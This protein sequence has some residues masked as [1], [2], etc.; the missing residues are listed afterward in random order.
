[1]LFLGSQGKN[2][3]EVCHIPLQWTQLVRPLHH[4]LS[5]LGGS[6][7]HGLVIALDKAVVHVVRLADFAVTVVSVCLCS[8]ALSELLPS[9]LG[10]CY[11]GHG[12]SLHGSSSK[13][14]S[15]SLLWV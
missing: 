1:M 15:C 7:W 12:V 9:Y 11:V 5:V 8:D 2:T 13:A 6:R 3:E 14:P 4:N 10:F